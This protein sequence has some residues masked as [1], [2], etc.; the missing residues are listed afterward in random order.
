MK[1]SLAWLL[2][3]APL[4]AVLRIITVECH[5]QSEKKQGAGRP[6]ADAGAPDCPN[7]GRRRREGKAMSIP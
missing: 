5:K 3:T 6:G 1:F 4:V 7:S 2:T